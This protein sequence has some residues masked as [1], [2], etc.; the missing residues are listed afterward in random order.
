[1]DL[2]AIERG[3]A[4][5]L[6]LLVKGLAVAGLAGGEVAP[7]AVDAEH[8]VVPDDGPDGHGRGRRHPV[9]GRVART[10]RDRVGAQGVE[11]EIAADEGEVRAAAGRALQGRAQA[12]RGGPL[13]VG[14]GKVREAPPH[15]Q[16]RRHQRKVHA[17]GRRPVPAPHG[18]TIARRDDED[19]G[20]GDLRQ[21]VLPRRV[22]GDHR[23]PVRD[24]H[25][26]HSRFARLAPAVRVGVREDDAGNGGAGG[27]E[28][29]QQ[30]DQRDA[31]S[32]R[33]E[34]ATP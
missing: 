23:R 6:L 27:E 18:R 28:G 8:V 2:A 1:V 26:R 25:A 9:V 30:Q 22:R 16:P 5:P 13:H 11:H 33:G 32:G 14:I 4:R 10:R 12:R 7:A 21:R 15:G 20:G 24:D 31:P 3:I 29:R 34:G 17:S 19:V